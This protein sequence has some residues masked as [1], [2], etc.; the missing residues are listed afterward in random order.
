MGLFF[1]PPAEVL[2]T[3]EGFVI[4]VALGDADVT[5]RLAH[6]DHHMVSTRVFVLHQI[7]GSELLP[8]RTLYPP[9]GEIAEGGIA[10]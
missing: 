3:P 1:Q 2:P 6:H 10:A 9:P 8:A 4:G 5:V 7:A